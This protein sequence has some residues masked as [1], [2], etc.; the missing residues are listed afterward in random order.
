MRD[1]EY[2]Y[3]T[4]YRYDETPR[5]ANIIRVVFGFAVVGIIAILV[6]INWIM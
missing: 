3:E 4:R 6:F 2:E 5:P 1:D